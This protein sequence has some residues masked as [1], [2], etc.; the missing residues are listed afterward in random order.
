MLVTACAICK[1]EE[2]NIPQWL[3]NTADFDYRVVVDTGS[4]DGSVRLLHD[5]GVV[6]VEKAFEPF[7]FDDARNTALELVP[8]NTNWCIWPDFDEYYADGWRNE[9]LRLVGEDPSVTRITYRTFQ[10]MDGE[11]PEGAESGTLM[12]SK[13]HKYGLYRWEKPVHEYL[14]YVG[15]AEEVV[16]HADT[17]KRYHLHVPSEKRKKLYF[18]IAKTAIEKNPDDEYTT[19]FLLKDYY[20]FGDL[21]KSAEYAKKY[22][23]RTKGNTDFRAI[24]HN[25]V[26]ENETAHM[27]KELSPQAVQSFIM[28]LSR[29]RELNAGIE[30]ARLYLKKFPNDFL[31]ANE[32]AGMLYQR[33]D[34]KEALAVAEVLARTAPHDD[35]VSFNLAKCYHIV[36]RPDDARKLLEQLYNKD[37]NNRDYAL[38]YALYLSGE[39]KFDEAE[40]ILRALRPDDRTRFNLGWYEMRKGNFKEGF[41]LRDFGRTEHLWGSEHLVKMPAEKRYKNGVPLHGKTMLLMGEGGMGDEMI[42]ARFAHIPKERGAKKV[43]V[44][45]L[46]QLV[47]IFKRSLKG[48]DEVLPLSEAK[49]RAYDFYIPMMNAPSLLSLENPV[50]DFPYLSSDTERH[51]RWKETLDCIADGKP[52][53]GI[54]WAGNPQF[55]HEQFR[56]VEPKHFMELSRYGQLFSLQRD[57][58]ADWLPHNHGVYDLQHD[59]TDWD[60]TLAAI[61]NLDMVV[62]SCTS[63]VHAAG[64]LGIPVCVIVPIASYFPWAVP[65]NKSDWYPSVTV[66][67]QEKPR[68]WEEPFQKLHDFLK[69]Y[70]F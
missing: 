60:E 48:V 6:V 54:R 49:E 2:K 18:E 55:E 66:F 63:I 61:A 12:E 36:G 3:K 29:Q 26:K 45:C 69:G 35:G 59:L 14:S 33:K 21:E 68:S 32:L 64:A 58:G 30:L 51:A 34:F 42:F 9:I 25:I 19:W 62:S 50:V 70:K 65:G 38:D 1:N 37:K 8:A 11:M 41:A 28:H 67:R 40:N 44:G 7:R 56:T 20:T 27:Q 16:A 22:L 57:W 10:N 15:D 43:I 46:P 53:I 17:I 24:A 13:I 31:I 4:T 39:G 5:A 47:S 23:E 52:K